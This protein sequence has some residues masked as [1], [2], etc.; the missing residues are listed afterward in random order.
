[1]SNAN[2]KSKV[3]YKVKNMNFSFSL[4]SIKIHEVNKLIC[5]ISDNEY[6]IKIVKILLLLTLLYLW[7]ENIFILHYQ[8]ILYNSYVYIIIS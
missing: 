7:L 6:L 1:M 2:I 4:F 5:M 8:I 3:K